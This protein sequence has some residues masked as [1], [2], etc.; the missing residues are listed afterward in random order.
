MRHGIRL[1][2]VAVALTAATLG[3]SAATTPPVASLMTLRVATRLP[4]D[5]ATDLRLM[6]KP[7]G[8]PQAAVLPRVRLLLSDATGLPLY[9]FAGTQ[10]RVCFFV[11]RGGG[12]CG[13]ISDRH[14]VLWIV[15]G[16]SHKR[17]Q[18]VV[19]VVSDGV[20]AVAVRIGGRVVQA[21]VKHNAF[22]LPFRMRPGMPLLRPKD[23]VAIS[24]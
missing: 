18:A 9:A 24:R 14:K 13:E 17:G 8:L 1:I 15:N 4:A 10:S 20:R 5:L 23:V 11:W 12:T 21:A 6:G 3:A 22:V 19:G 16:G 7:A 2:V